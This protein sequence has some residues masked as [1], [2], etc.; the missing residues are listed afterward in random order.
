M[1]MSIR[2]SVSGG[3]GGEGGRDRLNSG[4]EDFAEEGGEQKENSILNSI[5]EAQVAVALAE[6]KDQQQ[7][8]LKGLFAQRKAEQ[9]SDALI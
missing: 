1:S 7:A 5:K 8:Q 2:Q 9:V 3:G 6:L 4:H